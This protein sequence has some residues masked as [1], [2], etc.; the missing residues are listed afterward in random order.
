MNKIV[1]NEMSQPASNPQLVVDAAQAQ[2]KMDLQQAM[3][4]L[5]WVSPLE[6]AVRHAVLLGGKRIRPALVY[7]VYQTLKDQVLNASAR[8]AA[9]AVEFIHCYSLIHDDLPCMDDD[10]LRRGQPTCHVVYGEAN[11]LLAGDVLQSMAFDVL[12][13][14]L[15]APEHD[16]SM[17]TM[18]QAAQQ[19]QLL[20]K[21]ANQ[22]VIG[23]VLDLAAE[24][25]RVSEA[26]LREIHLS[27]TGALIGAAIGMGA[28]A[29]GV[30]PDQQPFIALQRFG[31]ALG[32]AF[33]VQDD[34][35]D[36]TASTE[37]LGKPA[38]S[39]EKLEK[40]TYPALL[41]LD[42]AQQLAQALHAQALDALQP[43]GE[44]A[45]P[46]RAITQFLLHR[47]Y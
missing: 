10:A 47:Q 31:Q 35:L 32:L 29:A 6:E 16:H 46:L 37:V 22:M 27:K 5:K 17:T 12:T 41:G 23:Q 40:S 42:G 2:I 43:F 36:V 9:V 3:D 34:I 14:S 11:A 45:A 4:H 38:G 20:A 28:I 26:H 19:V 21:G 1:L 44:S 24:Q 25:Q 33:Q 39:D 7:A 30:Q 13:S 8:R 18:V 15:F